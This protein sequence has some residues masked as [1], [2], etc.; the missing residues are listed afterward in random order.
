M[1]RVLDVKQNVAK[2]PWTA[3]E[4]EML[5]GLVA[6]SHDLDRNNMWVVI[7]NRMTERNGKQCRERWVNHLDPSIVKGAW[8]KEEEQILDDS[9]KQ[10]ALRSLHAS[11]PT[12]TAAAAG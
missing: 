6:E 9:H 1:P 3:E 8:S 2:G 5:R 12:I 7:G 4:D 11:T 10:C